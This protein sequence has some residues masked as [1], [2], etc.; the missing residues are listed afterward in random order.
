M[1]HKEGGIRWILD[2]ANVMERRS[3]GRPT[4]M[5]GTHT[6]ITERK[7]SEEINRENNLRLNRILDNLF[8]YVALLDTNSVVQE[9]NKAPLV[10]GSYRREQVIGQYFY[11]APWWNYDDQVR[12]QL[13]MAINAAKQG[14]V[15]RY[16][17]VVKMGNELTPIDF[18]IAPIYDSSDQIIGLLPTAVDITERKK[19]EETT[20]AA[21]QQLESMAATVPGMVYQ[22][23]M[24]PKVSG[25]S[26][27]SA[28][29]LKISMGLA[30]RRFTKT[31]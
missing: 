28:K 19:A 16:D 2:Q 8:T 31:I 4:R 1:L 14:K 26:Y 24:T 20:L 18:Q 25:N 5:S 29:V 7:Q 30:Q 12:T 22:L 27:M 9:I 6:D 23:M 10:R 15:S 13:L 17:V 21:K 11:D 3:D